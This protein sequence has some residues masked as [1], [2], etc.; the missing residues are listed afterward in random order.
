[1]TSLA[2]VAIEVA[3]DVLAS[4]L[5]GDHTARGLRVY[6]QRCGRLGLSWDARARELELDG[7]PGEAV[8]L[9]LGCAALAYR[10]A[11]LCRSAA[12]TIEVNR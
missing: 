11:N 9:A 3:S 12:D 8:E 10:A 5:A 4:P 7:A 6:Q 1:M 2:L